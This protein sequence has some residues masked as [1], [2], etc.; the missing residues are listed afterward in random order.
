MICF[1]KLGENRHAYLISNRHSM[2]V[3]I[4]LDVCNFLLEM[5]IQHQLHLSS[6]ILVKR[7]KRL[8]EMRLHIRY[9]SIKGCDVYPKPPLKNPKMCNSV[10]SWNKIWRKIRYFYCF[11]NHCR[12]SSFF[13]TFGGV[14]HKMCLWNCRK[15][16]QSKFT[17]ARRECSRM[18]I[19]P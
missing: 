11:V 1:D 7:E 12:Q 14:A 13:S 4:F 10:Q 19:F 9:S 18:S 15:T 17:L 3:P 2:Y 16:C 8:D 6:L 5:C